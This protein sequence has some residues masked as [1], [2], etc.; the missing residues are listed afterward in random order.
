VRT[1][2]RIVN[3]NGAEVIVHTPLRMVQGRNYKAQ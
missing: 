1:R 3:Q 2:N